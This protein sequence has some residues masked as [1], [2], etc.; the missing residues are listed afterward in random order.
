MS[1]PQVPPGNVKH[2]VIA[3]FTQAASRYDT[4]GTEFFKVMGARLADLADVRPGAHV[5]DVGWG[6][7]R[8]PSPPPASP[9]TPAVCTPSTWPPRC[10][11]PQQRRPAPAGWA[12]SPLPAATPR[13]RRSGPEPFDV[14]LAGNVIQFLPRPA[15]AVRRWLALLKPGGTVAFSWGL[16]QD[17][18]WELVMAAVEARVPAGIAGFEAFLRRSPF[19]GID[20]VQQMLTGTGYQAVQTV[21][22]EVNAV[23]RSPEQWW[24]A[25]Q[26]QVFGPSPGGTSPP[27]KS[28]P[29]KPPRSVNWRRSR[30][31]AAPT[32][33]RSRSPAPPPAG[34]RHDEK[35][36]AD[37]VRT[38]NVAARIS[39]I[40][41]SRLRG[42]PPSRATA[43]RPAQ[44][45]TSPP[46]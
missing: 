45:T 41:R 37:P 14:I 17:P 23:C 1:T 27:H 19:G 33:G 11:T 6:K 16:A 9:G 8:S 46:R 20:P 24:A 22:Y 3:G 21:T 42:T 13:T 44:R 10:W 5:L 29:P 32:P 35:R 15:D 26:C 34:R 38:G 18:R 40:N 25:S 7:A 4:G 2:Q 39:R 12:P 30:N 28:P 36:P 31:P 43:A